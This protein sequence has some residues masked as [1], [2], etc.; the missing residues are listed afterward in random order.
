MKWIDKRKPNPNGE[1]ELVDGHG[2][3]P[4]DVKLFEQSLADLATDFQ[5]RL[6]DALLELFVAKSAAA[7][8]I[9]PAEHPETDTKQTAI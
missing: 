3:G 7:V 5:S 2:S 4:V 1:N 8:I 6:V 9:H